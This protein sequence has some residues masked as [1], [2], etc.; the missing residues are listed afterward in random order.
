MVRI[1]LKEPSNAEWSV[2]KKDCARAKTNLLKD[3]AERK[4]VNIKKQIY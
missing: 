3:V 4:K 2:W 1:K